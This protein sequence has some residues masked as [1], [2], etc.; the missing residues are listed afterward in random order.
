M[1]LTRLEALIGSKQLQSLREKTVLVV[2]LGGVGGHCAMALA[3]SGIGKMIIVDKDSVDISNINRQIVALYSTIGRPKVGVLKERILDVNKDCEVVTYHLFYNEESKEEIFSHQIDF[4]CDCIDTITF[5]IDII[6]EALNRNIPFIS[7]MGAANKMKPELLEIS[8]LSKT[9]YD[10]IAKVIRTKLRKEKIKGKVPVV[11]SKE[12]PLKNE[13]NILG[14]NSF[15]PSSMGLLAASY[16][17]RTLLER[18]I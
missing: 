2:G 12:V 5:K 16:A 9:E 11:Y 17:I 15:V 18:K 13:E 3:R 6:K 14:S 1:E 4:V 8:E 10:P 7:A